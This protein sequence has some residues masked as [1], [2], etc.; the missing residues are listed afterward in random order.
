MKLGEALRLRSDNYKKIE[1][2]HGRAVASAQKQEG[3]DAPDSPAELLAEI[4]RLAEETLVIVQR[5]NRTNV[6]T[7]LGSGQLLV[8]ALAER[9]HQ[10][11][12]RGPFDGVAQAASGLQ[13]RYLRSEIRV[14]RTID[15]A[16]LRKRVD[17]FSR[18]HRLLDVAIQE[19]NWV[20][21][22]ADKRDGNR[23]QRRASETRLENAPLVAVARG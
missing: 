4:E 15:P 9:Q 20:T 1:E 7:K 18:R 22:L 16:E 11:K 12:L 21:D 3:T 19:V 10:V 5:I 13:Q 23:D 2:L 14:V 8:D 6:A 17:G